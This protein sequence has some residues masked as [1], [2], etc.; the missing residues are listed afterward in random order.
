[1]ENK[2]N[3]KFFE[4]YLQEIEKL[5]KEDKFY[6]S[7][8]LIED[9]G[10]CIFYHVI[11]KNHFTNKNKNIININN[12]YKLKKFLLFRIKNIRWPNIFSR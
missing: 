12:F 5:Q 4:E 7:I 3:F 1:M 10:K 2:E 8:N 6:E 9:L 11:K